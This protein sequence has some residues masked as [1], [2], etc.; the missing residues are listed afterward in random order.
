MQI[1]LR[2][3]T[4]ARTLMAALV[5]ML[6][7]CGGSSSTTQSS[8]SS[9]TAASSTP[10][11]STASASTTATTTTSSSTS[12]EKVVTIDIQLASPVKLD[13]IS[14]HYTCD[15]PNVSPPISWSHVPPNTAEI[16]LFL[17]NVAPVHG[18]LF[19]NWAVAG[20]SPKLRG[21][22]AGQLPAGAILGR[23]SRGQRA[24]SLCPAKGPAV[25]YAFLLYALPKKIPA[26][27]G[28]NAEELREKALHAAASA[29]LLGLSYK[30]H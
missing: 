25:R 9:T 20:I 4:I 27:T 5:L 23:N 19:A 21:L 18:K 7:G 16:D 24:Y 22:S 30:R 29:G 14:A 2:P 1:G 17:F 15:G 8:S 3:T 13:P 6:T 11:S 26:S 28:F 12:S 10:T